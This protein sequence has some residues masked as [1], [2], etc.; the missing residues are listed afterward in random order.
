MME[1]SVVK[2]SISLFTFSL[3]FHNAI[4][5]NITLVLSQ[6]PAFSTFNSYLSQTNLAGDINSRQTITILAVENNNLS[7]L[8]GKSPNVLKNIMSV[9]VILDYYDVPKI[10][11]LSNQS[12]IVTTLFQTTGLAKG[13]QGFVN[14]THLSSDTIGFGSAIP[15][16]TLG[17]NLVNSS[18]SPSPSSSAGASTA[19]SMA[20]RASISPSTAPAI[21]RGVPTALISPSSSNAGSQA[22]RTA[23][24]PGSAPIPSAGPIANAPVT[25]APLAGA[26]SANAPAEG[27]PAANAPA[28]DTP[29]ASTPVATTPATNGPAADSPPADKS[30]SADKALHTSLASVLTIV[31]SILCLASRI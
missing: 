23:A 9:H 24:T 29:V 21:S 11:K 20:P 2:I 10:Q 16:S 12:T 19:P 15:G 28:A 31:F 25:D 18:T 13:E 8:S 17:S 5:F 14:I 26:P 6:Y 4:A 1:M 22:P 30:Q 3:L 27:A 7:P